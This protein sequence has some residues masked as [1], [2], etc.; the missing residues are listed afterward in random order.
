MILPPG[1][2]K[3]VLTAHVTTSVGW[4]GAV[5]AYL[6]LD[7]ATRV[8][9]DVTTVRGAYIAMEL[10]VRY[11]IVPLA[12]AAV[13][14]GILNA[15]GTPWGLF[16]HYWV[17]IKLGLTVVAT[18]VLLQEASVVGRF[19]DLAATSA[20]PRALGSTLVHSGG[21]LLILLTTTVL[22]VFRPRGVTR[23]GWRKQQER[24]NGRRDQ[25]SVR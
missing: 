11:A 8:S 21:G 5:A 25:P 16:R 7:I 20:D 19:A 13:L 4:L 23:Y 14:I 22:S 9:Q 15:L 12:L 24:R 17:L 2:R 10:T 1:L 3:A 18:W 6:V